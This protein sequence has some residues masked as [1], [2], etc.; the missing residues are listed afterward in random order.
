MALKL[1]YETHSI[2]VDNEAGIATG[3][4]PGELSERGRAEA[5]KLG[6]RRRDVDVVYASD[7]RRAVQTAEIAFQLG[8]KAGAGKEIR[9]DRRLRECDYG[10]CNGRPVGEVAPLRSRHIDTPWP[11]GQSYRQVVAET[12]AFLRD[13]TE[14]WQGRTVLL[15]AHSANRWALQNLFDGEP[16]EK[17]VDAP[18]EWRPGWEW[19]REG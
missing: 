5:A 8:R 2:T 7:L 10:A 15:I 3:W 13:V 19:E 16:L 9:L 11:G 17:L 4:L 1:V 14:E 12:A 18:F 6:V